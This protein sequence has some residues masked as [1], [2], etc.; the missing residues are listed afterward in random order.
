MFAECCCAA[1]EE[2]ATAF[3]VSKEPRSVYADERAFEDVDPMLIEQSAATAPVIPEPKKIEKEYEKVFN[4]QLKE[5]IQDDAGPVWGFRLACSEF[6]NLHVSEL[7]FDVPN[8]PLAVY[9]R[10]ALH[11]R[12]VCEGDYIVA[13]NGEP[14]SKG[15]ASLM[16]QWK[17]FAERPRL[18][19]TVVRPHIFDVEVSKAAKPMGLEL[20]YGHLGGNGLLVQGVGEG[21]VRSSGADVRPG[22]RIIAV[23]NNRGSPSALLKVLGAN[24]HVQLKMSRPSATV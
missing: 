8:T 3:V 20:S 10:S 17:E 22:D 18:E 11:S 23:D 24:D 9:N 2:K 16:S 6:G 13:I 19:M 1:E 4:I 21:A 5:P 7:S 12:K 14:C 15:S